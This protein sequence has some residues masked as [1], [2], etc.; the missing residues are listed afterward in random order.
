MKEIQ[1]RILILGGGQAQID[2]IR[3]AKEMNL[4]VIVVGIIG[5][6]PGYELAD[7][8]YYADINDKEMVL[9]I[10]SQES[11]DGI[12][13]VCSDYGLQTLGYVCDKYCLNGLTETA[14][15][16][17]SNK[18]IMKEKLHEFGVNTAKFVRIEKETNIKD[19]I[20][21]LEYPLMV[22]AVDLQGSK[23]IFKCNNFED[24]IKS[25]NDA[26]SLSREDYCIVEE[27][28][29]GEEFGAQAF[30]CNDEIVFVQTHGDVVLRVGNS[31][32]PIG[33][34]MPFKRD[35][36]L[37]DEEIQDIVRKSIKALG[38]N[39]CAVNIDL[40]L[41]NGTPYIIELTG[42]AGANFLPEVTGYYLGL[43]YYEIILYNALGELS[44][45]Y[46]KNITSKKDIFVMSRQLFSLKDG[47]VQSIYKRENPNIKISSIFVKEG[48][49]VHKLKNSTDCIGKV[50]CIGKDK[51]ECSNIL[52]E[53]LKNDLIINIQ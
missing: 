53:Y 30:V 37:L 29:E 13:M 34:Y 24:V 48:D 32:I 11:I 22:K 9:D 26:M 46:F 12:C 4:Y 42:R 7:K 50:L 2:L 45:E 31:S 52:Y 14:A 38:F 19:A 36:V 51:D 39:N 15:I 27:F 20:S 35:D 21:G 49:K 33:H 47:I 43:N 5:I 1:K 16:E 25:Y 40:I 3:K 10:A 28:I 6:Y 44:E 8:V 23:G 41:R 18:Y 17:S